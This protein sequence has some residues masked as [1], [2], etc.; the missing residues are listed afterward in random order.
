MEKKLSPEIFSWQKWQQGSHSA[1]L[2]RLT[3][4]QGQNLD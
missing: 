4:L 1:T 3:V 2:H